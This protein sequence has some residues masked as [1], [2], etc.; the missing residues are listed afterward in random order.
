MAFS[1]ALKLQTFIVEP[2]VFGVP[3]GNAIVYYSGD[4]RGFSTSENASYRTKQY[5][6]FNFD[7]NGASWQ[8]FT[9]TGQTHRSVV[10]PGD[11][12]IWSDTLKQNPN[13]ITH[14]LV[15][16]SSKMTGAAD[17]RIQIKCICD[18]RNPFEPFAP[19]INYTF[20]VTVY[21]NG[22]VS[23]NGTQDGFPSYEAYV[24]LNSGS[25]KTL[26]QFSQQTI[27]SLAPPE[28]INVNK[29]LNLF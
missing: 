22:V 3:T 21:K 26:H 6:T 25:W 15:A 18:S 4:N 29:T 11:A 23:I 10:R 8:G 27:A 28:E 13:T 5:L 16:S 19:A 24:R 12:I 17:D 1:V 14:S 2:V 7:N 9:D 20:T